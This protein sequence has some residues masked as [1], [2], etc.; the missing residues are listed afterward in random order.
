MG[1]QFTSHKTGLAT[2]L[3]PEFKLKKQ[4]S[5]TFHVDDSAKASSTY[6]MIIG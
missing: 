5:W 2:F 3:L 6:A 4:I 1:G